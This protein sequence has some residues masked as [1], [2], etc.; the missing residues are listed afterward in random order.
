M[1]KDMD[2]EMET[3]FRGV[4]RDYNVREAEQL[5]TCF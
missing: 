1:A 2:N 5:P 3:G 4:Y